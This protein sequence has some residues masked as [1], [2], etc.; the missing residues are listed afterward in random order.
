MKPPRLSVLEKIGF[1]GGDAAVNVVWSSLALIITFFYTDVFND[2]PGAAEMKAAGLL[3]LDLPPDFAVPDPS[4]AAPDESRSKT[5]R[6]ASF[7]PT[8]WGTRRLR[9][10]SRGRFVGYRAARG[11]ICRPTDCVAAG[12]RCAR[13]RGFG[14]CSWALSVPF[15]GSS[16]G[17]SLLLFGGRGKLSSI[18]GDAAKGVRAFRDGL[19]G[20]DDK[21]EGGRPSRCRRPH[22][23]RRRT[24]SSASLIPARRPGGAVGAS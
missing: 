15:T 7:T 12:V 2:L 3:D 10:R 24:R 9:L 14:D 6:R 18:M 4:A 22:R 19:K 1:G 23:R 16:S 17:P 5:R 8:I 21:P 13:R 11:P 20:E